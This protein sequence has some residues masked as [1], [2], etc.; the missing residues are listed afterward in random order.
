[1]SATLTLR[2]GSGQVLGNQTVAV[3]AQG[4]IQIPDLA[5][6]VLGKTVATQTISTVQVVTT[7]NVL[8]LCSVLNTQNSDLRFYDARVA[9]GVREVLPFADQRTALALVND[10]L[11]PA[12]VELSM[13]VNSGAA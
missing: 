5:R 4:F 8:A 6:T 2:N 9:G 1:A 12:N 7:R 13:R 10:G 3:P 11:Q